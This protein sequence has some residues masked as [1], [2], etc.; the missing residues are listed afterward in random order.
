MIIWFPQTVCFSFSP[1]H[2]V[3]CL[4]PLKYL[5]I[6]LTLPSATQGRNQWFEGEKN[7]LLTAKF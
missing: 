3:C 1:S 4:K 5:Q 7:P 6:E 2:G